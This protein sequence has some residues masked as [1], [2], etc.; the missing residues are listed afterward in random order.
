MGA[1]DGMLDERGGR[2][3]LISPHQAAS[4]PVQPGVAQQDPGQTQVLQPH[5]ALLHA[6][7]GLV[8]PA[9]DPARAELAL[10]A[11]VF[12]LSFFSSALAAL[13]AAAV[14]APASLLFPRLQFASVQ[15]VLL[16]LVRVRQR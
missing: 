4:P 15:R 14:A 3:R 5:E 10:A 13:G 11:L 16:G 2:L 1:L 8:A 6:V 12:V 9:D 7:R